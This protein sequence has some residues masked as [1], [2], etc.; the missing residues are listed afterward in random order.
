MNRIRPA[1]TAAGLTLLLAWCCPYDQGVQAQE[2]ADSSN[3]SGSE[4]GEG[5]RWSAEGGVDV[6]SAFFYRGYKLVERGYMVQPYA[7]VSVDAWSNGRITLSPY[8]GLWNNFT[9]DAGP[10]SPT[11]YNELNPTVGLSAS[12]GT[13]TATVEFNYYHSP[14]SYF[15]DAAEVGLLLELDHPLAPQ[16]GLYQEVVDAVDTK[17]TY[18]ILG[19][20]PSWEVPGTRF[21]LSFPVSIGLSVDGYYSGSGGANEFLG[22]GSA[23][24][25]ASYAVS[26]HVA[27]EAGAE[28]LY[29]RAESVRVFNDG[30]QSGIAGWVGF[31][32]DL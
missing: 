30:E 16:V 25:A 14:S 29:L 1:Q 23:G 5:R 12:V 22:Y 21:S 26:E 28:Y 10:R 8:L 7:T 4:Q 24:G 15:E 20:E 31:S 6:P 27:L 18:A 3:N 19:A 11:F 17:D 2:Q 13:A 9:Q 32:F